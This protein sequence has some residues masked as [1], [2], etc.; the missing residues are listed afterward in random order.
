MVLAGRGGRGHSFC[1]AGGRRFSSELEDDL[2]FSPSVCGLFGFL[3]QRP[4]VA[5][6]I[7]VKA[8]TR[9]LA[10][11]GPD[12]EG[13]FH[14][15]A[16]GIAC[17]LAQTRLAIIDLSPGGHQPMRSASG[18]YVIVYNGEVYNY[19][20]IR[21]EIEAAGVCLR[22][23]SDTEAILEGYALWGSAVLERMRGMFAIAIWDTRLG[24]LFLARDRLGIKPLY[25]TTRGLDGIAFAS[26][27]RALL[28][29]G[30]AER[31]LSVEGVAS[32]L[33]WGSVAEPHTIVADVECLEPGT[34]L[35]LRQGRTSVVRYWEPRLTPPSVS[36][37]GAAVERVRPLLREAVA[38]R[39]VAD[40][41][42]GVFLSG[43]ID[44]S[45]ITAI[46]AGASERPMHSFNVAFREQGMSEAVYASEV[47]RRF[48]CVH[49]E[50]LLEPERVRDELD[51]A[52]G[53]LDQPSS[54]G[55]NTYF[56]AKAVRT[57]GISV[58][59]SG[60]GGDE[61]FAGYPAF[62]EFGR[63]RRLSGLVPRAVAPWIEVAAGNSLFHGVRR[64]T[65]VAGLLAAPQG[66][67]GTYA[68]LRCLFTPSQ[69]RKL[70]AVA[71]RNIAPSDPSATSALAR[72]D[73]SSRD[74]INVY[75]VLEL[76]NYMRN[77]L[78]RDADVMS[79]AHALEVRVPL[80]DHRLVETVLSIPGHLKLSPEVNKPL[81]VA[82]A[83]V[84]PD[85]VVHRRKM[86]FT[87][88][89]ETWLRGAL[90]ERVDGLLG[91]RPDRPL[92]VLDAREVRNVWQG[93]LGHD[94]RVGYSRVWSLAA[95]AAWCD[96][97]RVAS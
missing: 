52:L 15:E 6:R 61:L 44:S 22:S 54:D 49:H 28:V 43:G 96:M 29:S 40:V 66:S 58:V 62:R 26:E 85:E 7:D 10:H 80:I 19:A 8:A 18:R 93:F 63:A 89:W 50:V 73:A 23:H 81:L 94:R 82:S 86:G 68:A 91:A 3:T 30:A 79:M 16:S 9:A 88:P 78:L 24:D 55:V 13:T 36:S 17:S 25:F 70:L 51:E 92:P 71:G 33:H 57:E 65:K 87:L 14:G 84:L 47:A 34:H 27:V 72:A 69:V 31:R 37:F 20:E 42:V 83:P 75:S 38:L 59:L 1:C 2:L 64:A 32:Y 56:V 60:L 67:Q 76:T 90:R 48:G 77:T 46:A 4:E 95:L 12:D 21:R 41:P 35:T 5:A 74:V 45:V 11:R 53:A 39:L 97:N